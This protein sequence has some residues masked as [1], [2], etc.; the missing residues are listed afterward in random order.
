MDKET[1]KGQLVR[2]KQFLRQLYE[3]RDQPKV[4]HLLTFASVVRFNS[5]RDVITTLV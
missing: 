2:D 3:T 4:K 5:L 1:V